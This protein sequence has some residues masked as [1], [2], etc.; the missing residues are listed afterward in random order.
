MNTRISALI[1]LFT[2]ALGSPLRADPSPSISV[3]GYNS[4]DTITRPYGGSVTVTVR[5]GAYDPDGLLSGIRYNVWN[6]DTWY[7]DNGGGGFAP[8]SGY[9]GEVDET[10]TLDADGDWYV[11]T[12]AENSNGAYTSTGPW[13]S[14]FH[15]SVVQ[16]PPQAPSPSISVDGY[17]SGDSITRPYGG[18]VTITVRYGAFDPDGILSGIR[19]N[20]WNANTWYFDNGGGGFVPQS[21]Y[22]GEVDETVTLDSDGDWYFWTDAQNSA[23]AYASTGPWTDGFHINVTQAPNQPPTPS[24]SVD[25]FSNGATITRPYGG[26]LPLV[27]RYGATDPDGNLSGIR[28][29]VWNATTD[30]FDNGGGGFASQS[31][32]SGEVDRTVTLDGDGDWYFWT[33]AEDSAGAYA[34]T[35]PWTNGFHI[36][37][38]QAPS[39][40]PTP[41]I[42]VDGYNPGT[43]VTLPHGGS[44]TVTVHYAATDPEDDLSGIRYNVWNP[45]TGSFD[46]GGGFISQSGSSGEVTKTFTLGN[47][48][49]WYFWTDAQDSQG[50]Y[51]TTGPWTDG[52]KITVVP[53]A[54][55]KKGKY[56]AAYYLSWFGSDYPWDSAWGGAGVIPSIGRYISNA[57]TGRLHAQ[58]LRNMG[59][60]FVIVDSTN[61]TTWYEPDPIFDQ[62]KDVASG[63]DGNPKIAFLL[64][65]TNSEGGNLVDSAG[66]PILDSNGNQVS[67]P[68]GA[69]ERFLFD[70]YPQPSNGDW[71]YEYTDPDNTNYTV[72]TSLAYNAQ[73]RSLAKVSYV[74]QDYLAHPSR[75]FIW[76]GKPLLCFYTSASGRVYDASLANVI[77]NG[78]LPDS[79]NPIVPGTSSGIRDLFTLRW[80]GAF[81]S[82]SNNSAYVD[83]SLPQDQQTVAIYGNWSWEDTSPQ[84]WARLQNFWGDVP[85]TVTVSAFA[86]G[87]N[88]PLT[89][90]NGIT[91]RDQWC[92]AFDVDPLI[93]IIH[94]FNEFSSS[95]DEPSV[96]DSQAIETNNFYNASSPGGDYEEFAKNYIKF[97]KSHREDIGLYSISNRKFWLKN[98]SNDYIDPSSIEFDQETSYLMD[99]GAN[100]QAFSGDFNGDG[101]TG[102][103]LRNSDDGTIAIRS[104]PLFRVEATADYPAEKIVNLPTGANLAMGAGDVNGDGFADIVAYD[105]N[106]RQFQVY[107]NDGQ[108]N[109]SSSN[110]VTFNL[111][112]G[113]SVQLAC[114]DVGGDGGDIIARNVDT[115]QITILLNNGD[116][117]KSQPTRIYTYDWSSCSGPQYQ[118][119]A[120]DFN[121]DG[122][123]DLALRNSEDGTVHFRLNQKMPSGSQWLFDAS[124]EKTFTWTAGS[125]Y[126]LFS[127]DF[128]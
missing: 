75:Y 21:G 102:F 54:K 123:A 82:K 25:G 2:L 6:S 56:V 97:F 45:N 31:G 14:G 67:N 108:A 1:G 84:S 59:V 35:G 116:G 36:T 16:A 71:Q 81:V 30:Y 12:D 48:G 70:T 43:T 77:P 50:A 57:D 72:K 5:Y 29:N 96:E 11:W 88:P 99:R 17:N 15:L 26:S 51:A 3:D 13:T 76:N 58:E 95:G 121:G 9:W 79:W 66:N 33:D 85:E 68:N 32:A 91:F 119:I 114:A 44:I 117:M 107:F 22:W 92:R 78:T 20:V 103:A 105:Q 94:T 8:Q 24:I 80:V 87:G 83:T 55:A 52:F 122:F 7:F 65:I 111:D 49:D 125:D 10:V 4:G 38:V 27:V 101:F 74:Y 104:G 62:G 41:S 98:R 64:S 100:V 106:S 47:I 112:V 37:V 60:D 90:N 40:P 118:L 113:S 39:Q 19:Y 128:R 115:G 46:N 63:F 93:A 89:R 69:R 34:S 28:Y 23:G 73:S 86:R 109:F 126:Q 18:S 61:N 53:A 124:N 42:S 110:S 127:G 120:A